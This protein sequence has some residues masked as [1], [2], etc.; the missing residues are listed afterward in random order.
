MSRRRTCSIALVVAALL[1][2]ITPGADAV[3]D[4][5][6]AVTAPAAVAAPE[7]DL[8]QLRRK[9][10]WMVDQHGRV[11]IVHGFN[12]VWK[13]APYVP[14]ATRAGFT[15]ADARWLKRFG[16]N[17]VRLGTLWAGITPE[18]AGVGDPAYRDR[19]QRVMDLLTEQGIWMQLDAH[20][21]M[22]H[23]TYGGEGVPDWAMIRPA[24]FHLLPPVNLPFPMGYWTPEV[25]TVFDQFWA[26][27]HGLL[28]GW[29]AAWEVAAR[30]WQEQPYLMGYDLINEPWMGLE[31]PTCLLAGCQ[32]SYTNELQPAYEQA[33]AAI[34]A[35]DTENIVWWEPQQFAGGQKIPTFLEP[36]AGERRLGLSWHNYCPDVFLE[37]Q[38]IPGGDVENCWAFSRD[39]NA[40]ALDQAAAMRAVPMMS[41][42]GATDNL[43]AIE[44]DAAVADEHLMGWLHWAYKRWDDPTTADDAQGMFADD[45][46]LTTVKTEKL[47]RL[48]RTY[49][50]A[51]AGVPTAMSFD[52][53]SGDFRFRYRPDPG[54][55]APTEIFVSPL[56]YP[57][58][59]Q[60]SVTGG[61][62]VRRPGRMVHVT[63]AS[64]GPVTVTITGR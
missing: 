25:S 4:G 35:I 58:G 31:W 14:P 34:R 24:P 43:R 40:H 17:G 3:R 51:V 50:Q 11:V 29:V 13:R 27:Q 8:P 1:V 52:A 33:T 5:R 16:F 59:F 44:I 19:W 46:D 53:G 32:A 18:Q 48:V 61:T 30:W 63:P 6:S 45:A 21:D 49:A 62:A 2:G 37:S 60:V 39:R 23:E 7:P 42:W 9:G 26:D 54:I 38:G 55:A 36:M 64:E 56:H 28:D 10:R 15:A 12:L 41:E 47:R 20:Q 22:W 57:D